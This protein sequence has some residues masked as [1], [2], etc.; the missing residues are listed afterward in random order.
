MKIRILLVFCLVFPGIIYGQQRPLKTDDA[1]LLSV[2]RV[3]MELGAAF[4]QRQRYSLS[5][6]EGDL[7]R[8]AAAIG[9]GVGEYAEFQISSVFQ[10][11]LS[12]SKRTD[13]VVVPDIYGDSTRSVGNIT[14]GTK[15]KLVGEKGRRPAIA[16]KFAVELPNANQAHGLANDE[17]AFYTD[18]LF[19]KNIGRARVLGDLGFAILGSPVTAG[20]Q[21]D[22][23]TY[24][25]AVITPVH[26]R[27]NLVAG[28]SGREGPKAR[29][30]GN[31]N[32]SQFRAGIQLWT[33]AVRWDLGAV[34]GFK[35]YDP[36]SG[37]VAGATYEFQAFNKTGLPVKI[38]K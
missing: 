28:I 5:G 12:I 26:R 22:L 10:E 30:L 33:G 14:L 35:H 18:L 24:G 2:G 25:A 9:V 37:I 3:R 17:T 4:L 16:F 1:S 7:T 31:E 19:G 34:A 27:L 29:G 21:A 8:G 6:L 13:P 32:K 15:L 38:L 23:L 11:V 36:K 20:Q